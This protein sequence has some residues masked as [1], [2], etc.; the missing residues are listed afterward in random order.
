M[1]VPPTQRRSEPGPGRGLGAGAGDP[2]A[3]RRRAG[4][5]ELVRSGV[6]S[7]ELGRQSLRV[8]RTGA[9]WRSRASRRLLN[10]GAGQAPTRAP[11]SG[12]GSPGG[13]PT[14]SRL[15]GPVLVLLPVEGERILTA[16]SDPGSTLEIQ[17]KIPEEPGFP[18]APTQGF[19]GELL[20][21]EM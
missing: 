1:L 21:E 12:R 13:P 19:P 4:Q 17:N 15:K 2:S 18:G 6:R 5:R 11:V 20:W 3:S 7:L 10:A 14:L 16:R 9:G 8:E